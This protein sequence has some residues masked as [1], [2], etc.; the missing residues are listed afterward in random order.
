[1]CRLVCR[2]LCVGRMPT[3]GARQLSRCVPLARIFSS[4]SRAS[5]AGSVSGTNSVHRLEFRV[6]LRV[7]LVNWY[8]IHHGGLSQLT[9]RL[10]DIGQRACCTFLQ[11]PQKV[12]LGTPPQGR[13]PSLVPLFATFG[14]RI[15]KP[16]PHQQTD[17]VVTAVVG[18]CRRF[19]HRRGLHDRGTPPRP[20]L[21]T[22]IT[23][24]AS[25]QHRSSCA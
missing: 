24:Q 22:A 15:L 3:A 13:M 16:R 21:S 6:S 4:G 18:R 20:P 17:K 14:Y 7:L 11:P 12:F 19:F 9:T 5:K 1:M 10:R 2:A 25:Q 23:A 8:V